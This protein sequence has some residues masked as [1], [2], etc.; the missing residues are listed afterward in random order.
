MGFKF[1]L[2][3]SLPVL[4]LALHD[5]HAA[6]GSVVP[7]TSCKVTSTP[8]LLN[9]PILITFLAVSPIELHVL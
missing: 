6:F 3:K 4:W 7:L 2:G 1:L 8:E 9:V 5:S